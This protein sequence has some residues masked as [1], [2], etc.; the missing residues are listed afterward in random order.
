MRIMAAYSSPWAPV[1]KMIR[2]SGG[3]LIDLFARDHGVF[4]WLKEAELFAYLDVLLHGAAFDADF[5]AV[6][7]GEFDYFQNALEKGRESG[8]NEAALDVLDYFLDILVHLFFRNRK[9]RVLDIGRICHEHEHIL[10]FESAVVFG[11]FGIGRHA[12]DVVEL[13]VA[14][15]NY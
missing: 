2:R 5:L 12:V 3:I 10:I 11:F 7:F 13:E 9:A 1:A 8:D 15:V 4:F 14:G 6:F